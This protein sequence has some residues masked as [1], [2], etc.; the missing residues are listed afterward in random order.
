MENKPNQEYKHRRG[1]LFWPL[2]LIA[3]GIF[4]L[5]NTTN[6]VESS[7]WQMLL[8]LWPL[9]LVVAGLD[10]IYRRDGFVGAIILIGVGTIF[11]LSNLGVVVIG[12]WL[13]LLQFWPILLIAFGLDL[14]IGSRSA[15]SAILGVLVGIAL[16][17][18][19]VWF[20]FISPGG[21]RP[22][23]QQE[24]LSQ[25]LLEAKEAEVAITASVGNLSL[26]GGA[27]NGLLL[28]GAVSRPKNEQ[29][30]SKYTLTGTK[31][32]LRIESKGNLNYFYPTANPVWDIL[33]NSQTDIDLQT[34]LIAGE[35]DLDLTALNVQSLKSETVF[36]KT[37]LTLPDQDLSGLDVSVT[38][39]QLVIIVPPQTG[40]NITLDTGITNIVV[41]QGYSREEG[42]ISSANYPDAEHKIDISIEQPIGSLV[43]RFDR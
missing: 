42:R 10:G 21:L 18:A 12:S 16:L 32:R 26:T 24:N 37:T 28:E 35:Q 38:I 8:Q 22:T 13:M 43:I 15:T 27:E 39:G 2:L 6:V 17:G 41:P 20:A 36:G 3:A 25:P 4:L 5:L 1:S 9:L 7:P 31:G 14:I 19:V 33:L 40:L 11:L 29:I 23:L 30:D 34:A